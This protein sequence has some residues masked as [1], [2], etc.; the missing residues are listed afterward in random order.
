MDLELLF[1]RSPFS[2]DVGKRFAL[3]RP[4]QRETLRLDA[5]RDRRVV[6]IPDAFR[7]RNLLVEAE[8]GGVSATAVHTPNE[9]DVRIV[10][11]YG[12]ATVLD[13]KGKPMPG[14]YVK[15]Y[16]RRHDGGVEFYKD[17]Y[18]DLRGRFDYASL[19]TDDL[20]DVSRFAL[21]AS[22]SSGALIR[23]TP[24]PAR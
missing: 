16:A 1:S 13:A 4:A 11:S 20:V 8:G 17:G 12:Q 14:V 19:S 15:V 6:R 23:E 22:E 18:T 10:S 3:V 21:F 9:L 24:P 7:G 5:D 2:S